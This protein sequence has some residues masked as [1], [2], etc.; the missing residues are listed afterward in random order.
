M[1]RVA[2][3]NK[4]ALAEKA[5]QML[6]E[7]GYRQRTD[8]KDLVCR[9][10]PNDIEF[11]Y[12]RPK[13]IAT[14]VGSG[15]LDVGITGRDLL[16]DSGAPAEEV[17]DLAFA[18]ATFRF[19]ARPQDVDDVRDLGGHRIATAYP[20]LVERH[21]AELGVK[22]DVIR[23]DGAVENAIRLGV[24]DVVADVVETGATLRQAGL[25]VFGEPLLRSSAVLVRRAGTPGGTQH[26]QLLRR[27]H[28]VLVARRYVM[29]AYDVPAGLL[30]RASSLTPGIESPTV[31]PLHREGWVAVQAMV[32][33]DDVHRIMDELY[34]L[35][36]RAILVTNIHACRL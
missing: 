12:L 17:V 4:G 33:R 31:S 1:L 21:L 27:L 8:P 18:Q 35:G 11:F 2:V 7:A 10:E 3:P 24:A 34:E 20:G 32:L 9:D 6:R 30:D 5:A 23:L 19:A 25:V 14:Y 16:I 36:A 15:D 29:L 26:E 28:G 22:A 13:D